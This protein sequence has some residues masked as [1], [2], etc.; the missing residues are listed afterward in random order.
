MKNLSCK[1]RQNP[2]VSKLFYIFKYYGPKLE[3]NNNKPGGRV[4]GENQKEC[5]K[6]SGQ[7]S[8]FVVVVVVVVVFLIV[9]LFIPSIRLKDKGGWFVEEK[10]VIKHFYIFLLL[11]GVELEACISRY[12]YKKRARFSGTENLVPV[13]E[14]MAGKRMG[15][16][17]SL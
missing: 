15:L 8:S 11:H 13:Q 14:E 7:A 17:K 12:I 1:C 4:V 2:F 5:F 9:G 6:L 3:D 10:S 16:T